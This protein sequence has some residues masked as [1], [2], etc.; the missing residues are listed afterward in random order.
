LEETEETLKKCYFAIENAL[1]RYNEI[2]RTL[3]DKL[4]D[5]LAFDIIKRLNEVEEF[6]Q[7]AGRP[8]KSTIFERKKAKALDK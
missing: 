3:N 5:S 6:L 7:D 8:A 2:G 1:W 4:G